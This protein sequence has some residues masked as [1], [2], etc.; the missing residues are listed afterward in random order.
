MTGDSP[1]DRTIKPSLSNILN[2][3]VFIQSH[4]IIGHDRRVL[5][6][7]GLKLADI[8]AYGIDLRQETVS[9]SGSKY[10]HTRA[11]R[12]SAGPSLIR[13]AKKTPKGAALTSAVTRGDTSA[14]GLGKRIVLPRS[15][16]CCPRN[17][18]EI[19][20]IISAELP[21]LIDDPEG[22]KVVT[23]YMLHGPCG[24]DAKYAPC[25]T[26]KKCSK[27]SP[28]S[29]LA[30]TV[31]DE[32]G[33]AIYRWRNNKVT[34]KKGKFVYD[35]KHVV[36]YN[37]YLLL[38]Y[39]A[40]VNVEW[41]N[42]SKAIKYLFKYL[43]KGP[44]RATVVIQENIKGGQ[45]GTSEQILEVDEIKNFQNCWFLA[46][47]EAMWRLFLYDIHYSYP[48]VM[49]LSY[50][51]PDQNAITM[52]DSQNLPTLLERE[53]KTFLY[54]TIIARLRSARMIVLAVASSGI[55]SL[56]LPGGR[57]AHSRF[58][59]PLELMKNST[60]RIKQN[61]HLAELMQEV[62]LFIW[63]ETQM[64]QRYAFEAL[65]KTLRDILG[66]QKSRKK[67]SPF[68]RYNGVTG[69][70]F[71]LL[72]TANCRPK[73]EAEDEPT[74]IQIPEEFLFKS[75]NS[76]IEKIVSETYPDFTTRQI[77]DQCLKERVILTPRN[78]DADAI[79][80]Y[81]FK[82]LRGES[83]T[84]NSANEIYKGST[85]T[86]D[87][88]NLYP[89]EFLNSLNFLGMPPHALY[90]K[91]ELPITLM[92]NVD[93]SKGLCNGTRLIITELDQFII[94][95]KILTGSHTG[96]HVVIH[97]IILTSAKSKW[98]FVLKRRQ[99]LVKP[100]Y[101]MIINKSQ[102][103]SLNYVS[104]Y[105]PNPVFS[106]GQLYVTLSRVTTPDGLKILMIEDEDKELKQC[107][108]NIVFK[109]AF[110]NLY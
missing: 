99:F 85:D 79:N 100:C 110:N 93:Q 36:P 42:R 92:R 88:H 13:A 90:L 25:T 96:D 74:W 26:D 68:W 52:C 2:K 105:L 47:C 89:V 58:V 40:H 50:H 107:T 69:D 28:K 75:W 32:D 45:N 7:C 15:F 63:D 77:D 18:A 21:S 82:K 66:V 84:Y 23:E 6:Y 55:A 46:P 17:P 49:Q 70:G 109:E 73:K 33:Y 81:M 108:R 91:K 16:T 59:I 37:R 34:A 104:L 103:Q 11:R 80:E 35:N 20:D 57:T 38:K 101:A 5:S 67:E 62:K 76:P 43:N 102:G 95:V 94:Q 30:E 44:D 86:L 65:N 48:T 12:R 19:D 56:L 9:L 60:C 87:H 1:N 41:C 83:V 61:T 10:A 106:H 39:Q 97:R 71:W 78:D 27:H 14:V 31:I 51:L 4:T 24:A 8:R 29:F 72:V 53:G 3:S 22:Y 54:K 64:T 98:P